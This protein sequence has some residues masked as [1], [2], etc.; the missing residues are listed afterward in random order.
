MRGNAQALMQAGRK[1]PTE[2]VQHPWRKIESGIEP[3]LAIAPAGKTTV[4]ATEYIFAA[5]ARAARLRDCERQ[6]CQRNDVIE[7]V[8]G[9]ATRQLDLLCVQ[10]NLATRQ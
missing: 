4:A 1:C 8:L 10:I 2:I 5:F 9:P 6:R 3:L 7:P